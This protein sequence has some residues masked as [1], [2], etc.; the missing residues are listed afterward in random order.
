MLYLDHRRNKDIL[1]ELDMDLIEKK[2]LDINKFN[3]YVSTSEYI[4]SNG[5]ILSE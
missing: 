4:T 5:R 2:F 1:K 3:D